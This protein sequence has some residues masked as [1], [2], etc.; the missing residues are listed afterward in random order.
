MMRHSLSMILL[1]LFVN[2]LLSKHLLIEVEDNGKKQVEMAE[3][4]NK[5]EDKVLLATIKM[6]KKIK[7]GGLDLQELK[8]TMKSIGKE[9]RVSDEEMKKLDI[10]GNGKIEQGEVELGKNQSD[11]EDPENNDDDFDTSEEAMES[12]LAER[13]GNDYGCSHFRCKI[14]NWTNRLYRRR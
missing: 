8:D 3:D 11:Y 4:S 13:F 6:E 5:T 1:F 7:H 12:K 9:L 10:N 2:I 14:R